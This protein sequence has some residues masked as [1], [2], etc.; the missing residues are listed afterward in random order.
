MFK[1]NLKWMMAIAENKFATLLDKLSRDSYRYVQCCL[2]HLL[3]LVTELIPI[4][5]SN[6]KEELSS[7]IKKHE[8][9]ND[10]SH[11]PK[12]YVT[13]YTGLMP[14]I[15]GVMNSS[16]LRKEIVKTQFLLT[17]FEIYDLSEA[18]KG[19]LSVRRDYFLLIL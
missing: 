13:N 2:I 1:T 19:I 18:T 9:N 11:S 7:L 8:M 3:D 10:G 17:M 6:I 5:L 16:L 15:L 12:E 4:I 14:I